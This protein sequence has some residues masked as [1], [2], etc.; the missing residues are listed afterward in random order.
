MK[1]TSSVVA[2]KL[3]A[4]AQFGFMEE[5]FQLRD[6]PTS[7]NSDLAWTKMKALVVHHHVCSFNNTV[8]ILL[9]ENKIGGRQVCT[10]AQLCYQIYF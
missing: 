2:F 7:R 9:L 5:M 1:C 10:V 3:T 6:K 8:N 4:K